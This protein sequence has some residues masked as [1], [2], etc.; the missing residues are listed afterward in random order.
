MYASQ[1]RALI[2]DDVRDALI[3]GLAV[4]EDVP[5]DEKD[6]HPGSNKQV[7]D[8]VHPSLYPLRIGQSLMTKSGAEQGTVTVTPEWYFEQRTDLEDDAPKYFVSP[9]FQWL[10]TDFEVTPNEDGDGLTAVPLGYINNLH[11]TRHAALYPVISKIIARFI[12]LWERVLPDVVNT[13]PPDVVEVDPRKWYDTLPD[14]P[15]DEDREAY[16][17]YLREVRWPVIPS[18]NRSAHP[19]QRGG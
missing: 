18:R 7:L 2:S 9:E 6:W 8:L 1:A 3:K 4:L 10:P 12:P 16:D 5:E 19:A 14:W 11:P 17:Q 13:A 15:D